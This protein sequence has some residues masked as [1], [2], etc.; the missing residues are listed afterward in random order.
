MSGPTAGRSRARHD[1][2]LEERRSLL[3]QRTKDSAATGDENLR[4]A[5]HHIRETSV[6]RQRGTHPRPRQP[7]CS[8]DLE[9]PLP[10]TSADARGVPAGDGLVNASVDVKRD[11]LLGACSPPSQLLLEVLRRPLEFTDTILLL[12][13]T[14]ASSA[15]WASASHGRPS[16]FYR[17]VIVRMRW[18]APIPRTI[19]PT[20]RGSAEGLRKLAAGWSGPNLP[21]K[22]TDPPV[23]Q[24]SARNSRL[25]HCG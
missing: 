19:E 9:R 7:L 8:T 2:G 14:A 6:S 25:F 13:D 22:Q 11:P 1:H 10:R 17:F 4:E 5:C 23:F 20:G 18:H 3:A 15:A 21:G 24:V 12:A 16:I